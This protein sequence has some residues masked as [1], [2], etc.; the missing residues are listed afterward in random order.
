MP[1]QHDEA[2]FAAHGGNQRPALGRVG[3][4]EKAESAFGVA[5]QVGHHAAHPLLARAHNERELGLDAGARRQGVLAQ[6]VG[7]HP[8]STVNDASC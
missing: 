3:V 1:G 4:Q 5:A 8:S 7:G 2:G 6:H